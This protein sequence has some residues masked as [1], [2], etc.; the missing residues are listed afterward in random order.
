M[1]LGAGASSIEA[2]E[3]RGTIVGVVT[4]SDAS[5]A[6]DGVQVLLDRYPSRITG[7][8]GRFVFSGVATGPH[9]LSVRRIGY[10]STELLVVVVEG[11]TTRVRV[12]LDRITFALDTVKVES[13]AERV[14][15]PRLDP[16]ERH[17]TSNLGRYFT[18]TDIERRGPASK[19]TDL[20]FGTPSVEV[21]TDYDGIKR[22]KSQRG[23][24]IDG[25][26]NFRPC[27]MRFG[28]DGVVRPETDQIDLVSLDDI[29]GVEVFSGSAT[30][31]REYALTGGDVGC[32]LVMIWIRDR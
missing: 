6:I 3:R 19:V 18:R 32:G 20:L 17:R 31:P 16:F 24:R 28:V 4:D 5:T 11:D 21:V 13:R 7:A 29:H 27:W 22:L 2:Q 1:L 12:A 9:R 15:S 14:R 10:R 23:G 8:D 26:G 25:A 30:I